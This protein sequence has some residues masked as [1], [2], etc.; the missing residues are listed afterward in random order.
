MP[1]CDQ[2]FLPSEERLDFPVGGNVGLTPKNNQSMAAMERCC[3]PQPVGIAEGCTLWCTLPDSIM[4]KVD[5]ETDMASALES[6]LKQGN[7]SSSEIRAVGARSDES[8]AIPAARPITATGLSMLMLLVSGL[9][10][11]LR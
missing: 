1:K 10:A 3:S 4:E 7:Q 5:E 11:I 6:C 9:V 8:W 2:T